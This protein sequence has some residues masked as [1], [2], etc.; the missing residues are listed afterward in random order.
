MQGQRG[1]FLR[2]SDLKTMLSRYLRV[3]VRDPHQAILRHE[4]LN[5]LNAVLGMAELLQASGLSREQRRWL[6]AIRESGLQMKVLLES[7]DGPGPEQAHR[8]AAP[9]AADGIEMLE[10]AILAHTPAAVSKGID[11]LLLVDGEV[12]RRWHVDSCRLRQ[13]VDNLLGNAVKFTDRGHVLLEARSRGASDAAG[14][15]LELRVCDTGIGIPPNAS[16]A[17]LEAFQ[18]AGSPRPGSGLGLHVCRRIVTAMGGDISFDSRP[19][20]GSSFRIRL[21]GMLA[22]PGWRPVRTRLLSGVSALVCLAEPRLS[23]VSSLL[24]RLGVVFDHYSADG[25][26]TRPDAVPVLLTDAPS[27]LRKG[28]PC[29]DGVKDVLILANEP[30]GTAIPETPRRIVLNP[31]YLE[32]TIG[33]A[34]MEIALRRAGEK[35]G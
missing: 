25:A 4:L 10:H 19:G 18:K 34:L 16:S 29:L 12:P 28:L 17:V 7:P 27:L 14:A 24:M 31:P 26:A 30:V 15:G 8:R 33:P 3:G 21:P 13:V 5:P 35:P 2:F 32:C 22:E 20:E 11:L 1:S 9:L 6:S 23:S